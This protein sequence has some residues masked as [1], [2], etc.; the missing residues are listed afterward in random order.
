MTDE[1][2]RVHDQ[3]YIV[4]T[5]ARLDDRTRVLKHGDTFAVFDRY[6]DIESPGPPELG[7][8]H[9]DTRFL[10]R[11]TLRLGNKRPMLLSS[12][13][14]EDNALLTVDLTNLDVPH[15]DQVIVP[16]GT[17]HIFRA[18]LL[19][20]AA[21]Y[22]RLRVH[23]YGRASIDLLFEIEFDADYA[24]LFEVRGVT[25]AKRGRRFPVEFNHGALKFA[26]EGLDRQLRRTSIELDP[27]PA[28][29]VGGRAHYRLE[30]PPGGYATYQFVI[31]CELEDAAS[32]VRSNRIALS[33]DD[34]AGEAAVELRNARLA[35]PEIFTANEQF[36]DWVNRSIADLHMMRTETEYGPYPYAGVPWFSTVFG[37]DGIISALECL[38]FNPNIAR[39]VLSYLAATQAEKENAE[40]DSQPGKI[41]HERRGGEMAHLGEV[42]FGRYYGSVD[43]TPLFVMLA[44]AYHERSGDDQF[45]ES[46]WPNVERALLWID[47]FG[48]VDGDGFVEY[49]RRSPRGLVNQGWKDS[50][51]AIFHEDGE[52]AEPPIALSEVQGYVFAAKRA[53]AALAQTLQKKSFAEQLMHE[54]EQLRRAFEKNFWCDRLGLYGLALDGNKRLC[55]VRTSNAGHSLFTGIASEERASRVA[56]VLIAEPFFSGWGVRTVAGGEARYNPMSYHN[57]SIWPHDNALIAAGCARYGL[58]R[59]AAKILT[60]LF[61]ASL[62]F[63][64][65]RLPELFCGFPRRPGESP[66]LYPVACSPQTWASCAVFPLL[67]ACLGLVIR[68]RSEEV[69]FTGPYLP[70]FLPEVRIRRLRVGHGSVDLVLTRRQTDVAVDV[71]RREGEVNVHV[72]R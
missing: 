35:E 55:R 59:Q 50:Q 63:D 2:I 58:K 19:R 47:K 12:T 60:G 39:G 71:L 44:G 54:A 1:L 32:R 34:V 49:S 40:Q 5:S 51:D 36:N 37:R 15:N 3:F 57:G 53:A 23:N 28:G 42:P 64:L 67:Q 72:T 66:T 7:I 13:V 45:I 62:F 14:K 21:C 30:L 29:L 18:K 9:Q 65:H 8:Y 41:L 31:R 46:I 17:L 25:R 20:D 70:E 33:Y 26:Y 61:D 48:D 27:A 10:S 4:S 24:D 22:D 56:A 11:L 38:W 52:L 69:V 16:R 6:G 68:D 43:A